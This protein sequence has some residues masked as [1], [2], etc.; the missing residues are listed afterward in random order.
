[1]VPER[2]FWDVRARPSDLP[3]AGA[4]GLLAVQLPAGLHH[5]VLR[6][7]PPGLGWGIL[8]TLLG[9]FGSGLILTGAKGRTK[10]ADS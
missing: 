4:I 3:R 10:P 1:M 8:A 9:L 6:H 5:I 2:R 7:R